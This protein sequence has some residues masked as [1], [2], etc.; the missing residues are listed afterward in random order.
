MYLCSHNI[1]DMKRTENVKSYYFFDE[2]G[3]T[4]LLGRKGVNQIEQGLAS[5]TFIVGYLETKDPVFC[6][7]QLT[8]LHEKI[9]ED[10]YLSD[11]PSIV[12]TNRAFHANKDCQEVKAEV[13]KLLKTLDIS[14]Y[15]IVARKD[16]ARFKRMFDLDDKQLYKHLV[17]KLLEN[18]LHQ[19]CEIDLYFSSMGNVVRKETMED[20][21]QSA[22]DM[23][24]RKWQ[25]ENSSKHRIIIQQN[26]VEPLLQAAD[27]LLWAVQ[28]VYERGEY[29]YYNYMK[30]KITLVY[31]IF[32]TRKYREKG[33]SVFYTPN[34]PLE[35]KK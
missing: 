33:S 8:L 11:V 9:K 1:Y 2:A 12:S 27:Y 16:A 4:C 20:A 14:F 29:R 23:F 31:D 17:S 15:C 25:Y 18:R 19:Y 6:R 3:D 32:D 7:K 21:I 28:R 13:F 30:E 34:N 10:V 5:K 26:S 35:A 24:E 22:I